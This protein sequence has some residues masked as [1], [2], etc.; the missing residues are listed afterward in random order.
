MGL[1]LSCA[2]RQ[3]SAASKR[4]RRLLA[5]GILFFVSMVAFGAM[6]A[7]GLPSP[8][9]AVSPPPSGK[10]QIVNQTGADIWVGFSSAA[11]KGI[12]AST[13]TWG[14]GCQPLPSKTTAKVLKAKTCLAAVTSTKAES[15]FCAS[16]SAGNLDCALAQQHHQTLIETNFQPSC[17][18]TGSCIWY[19]ISVISLNPV[20]THY[21]YCTDCTWN[22]NACGKPR[23]WNAKSYCARTGQVAY[24][25]PV[26]LSCSKQPTYICRGPLSLTGPGL[27][28]YG[29]AYPKNCGNP[30]AACACGSPGCSK[31]NCVA[32]YFYPMSSPPESKHEPNAACPGGQTLAMNFLSGP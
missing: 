11:G 32:A 30:N 26:E 13:I 5:R 18:N 10:V 14:A 4:R 17:F 2:G 21:G 24:N 23:P 16:K 8:V 27:L 19:D 15:R 6:A 31:A 12:P 9:L 22:G 7:L 3:G 25:L 29:E 20:Q 1:L 28:K